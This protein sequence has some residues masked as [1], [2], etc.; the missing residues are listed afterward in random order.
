MATRPDNS[1]TTLGDVPVHYNRY[2][3]EDYP[4]R[5]KPY[6]YY[7]TQNFENKLDEC[8]R[9]LWNLNP[10]GKAEVITSGGAFV[11]KGGFHAKG[12]ALDLDGI[13]WSRRRFITLYDGYQGGNRKFYFGIE[14]ILRKHFGTVLDYNYNADHRD[15]FH[16]DDEYSVGFRSSSLSLVKFLQAALV[17][18][19]GLS[20][21]TTGIDGDY[22][23][24]TKTAVRQALSRL[25]IAGDI[26]N[27]SV[28]LQFLTG[29]ARTAFGSSII[30]ELLIAATTPPLELGGGAISIEITAENGIENITA[31]GIDDNLTIR[32][33]ANGL[34]I[35][36]AETPQFGEKTILVKGFNGEDQ[37][38]AETTVVIAAERSVSNPYQPPE[39]SLTSLGAI[40]PVID[41]SNHILQPF[42]D[43]KIFLE[44]E[45]GELYIDGSLSLSLDGSP[46][47]AQFD[48]CRGY[49]T[50]SLRDPE[51]SGQEQYVNSEE[52]PYV[53]LPEGYEFFGVALGDIVAVI[54]DGQVEFAVF[55]NVSQSYK[56][57]SGS[58]ALTRSLIG[59]YFDSN[60]SSRG[61]SE[62][63]IYLIFPGSGDGTPQTPEAIRQIGRNL[64]D[65]LG[66]QLQA[67][68]PTRELALQ[69]QFTLLS[70]P[71]IT[72]SDG[73][74]EA[75]SKQILEEIAR[76]QQDTGLP[77][78]MSDLPF[79][80][81][82]SDV[83]VLARTIFGEARGEPDQGK[84]G[85]AY[86]VINRV[87]IAQSRG[88]YW[89]GNTIREVCLKPFQYSCWNRNDPNRA[90]ILAV[91][92]GERV[93]DRCL[94]IARQVIERA[95]S[96]PV[97]RSTHYYATYIPAPNWTRGATF[98]VQLG[99]HKFYK[100]VR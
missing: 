2:R 43:C 73:I 19:F 28:W 4:T 95:I 30:P 63:V 39:T 50:T 80:A 41:R 44:L 49:L 5:G 94:V 76:S 81:I 38:V 75:F 70:R 98:F 79:E 48:P 77:L 17:H 65:Q 60:I 45:G 52:I 20:V 84:I 55:A 26:A 86:T 6:R 10:Y 74:D 16:V 59:D 22:G 31:T 33:E 99:I 36:S 61:I 68:S 37:Q 54:V 56:R 47:A 93:F 85:V 58:L 64:F 11:D 21:G 23:N 13:F 34:W 82:A 40:L 3:P 67:N 9:E 46:R 96:N 12:R 62:S 97:D 66:G 32:R 8:I 24:N 78:E 57:L 83:D 88:G 42:V 14:A 100:N 15:H 27:Q 72:R 92:P 90:I 53:A 51:L 7:C 18:V 91:R 87:S 25:G 89:W 29:T 71:I 69:N 35:V 1:F